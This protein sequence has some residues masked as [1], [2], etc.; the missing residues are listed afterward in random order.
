MQPPEIDFYKA[1]KEFTEK[2]KK[3]FSVTFTKVSL[4]KNEGGELRT[5]ENQK[6]GALKA[7]QNKR[8]MIGLEDAI[9]GKT[10]HIYLHTIL[11]ITL[12][13]GEKY[14]LKLQ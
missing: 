8:F 2:S 10:R 1:I 3:P 13:S 5:L 6:I 12:F 14:K 9:S 7:N 11:F 4:S